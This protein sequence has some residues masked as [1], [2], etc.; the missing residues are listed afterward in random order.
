[1]KVNRKFNNDVLT[2]LHER[3]TTYQCKHC[4][5]VF[6]DSEA[7]TGLDGFSK[8]CPMCRGEATIILFKD[9]AVTEYM[10]HLEVFA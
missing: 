9:F 5:K 7:I 8:F 3:I 1:M 4:G 6:N 10:H 2:P